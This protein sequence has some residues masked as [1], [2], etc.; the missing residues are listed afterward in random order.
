MDLLF[1]DY[2][3][4]KA[5]PLNSIISTQRFRI[6][7]IPDVYI[8]I[9]CETTVNVFRRNTKLH[10]T[11]HLLVLMVIGAQENVWVYNV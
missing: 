6:R 8:I 2:I 3:R 9:R 4:S 11:M 7:S 5:R 1:G 10:E